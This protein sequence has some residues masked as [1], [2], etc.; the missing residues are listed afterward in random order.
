MLQDARNVVRR[1]GGTRL[2]SRRLRA[3]PAIDDSRNLMPHAAGRERNRY[4]PALRET[5]LSHPADAY[6]LPLLGDHGPRPAPPREL[7]HPRV[8]LAVLF[9]FVLD[10]TPPAPP[11]AL[12]GRGA[13]RATRRDV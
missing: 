12:A 11:Q 3:T 7:E 2:Q 13:E 4:Q 5:P 9:P 8:G 1:A 10:K 6:G